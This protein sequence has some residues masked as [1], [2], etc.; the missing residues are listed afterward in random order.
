MQ[1]IILII[2]WWENNNGKKIRELFFLNNSL[3]R[4]NFINFINQ[5]LFY[6][7]WSTFNPKLEPTQFNFFS[8]TYFNF[9]KLI[10][11]F[12]NKKSY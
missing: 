8:F 9:S 2:N 3:L 4:L 12:I 10:H 5:N 11:N 6:M 1:V 7:G